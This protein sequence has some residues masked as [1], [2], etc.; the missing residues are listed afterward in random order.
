[1]ENMKITNPLSMHSVSVSNAFFVQCQQN[2]M[3]SD[4]D[5]LVNNHF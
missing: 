1:M 5:K 3:A 4:A 2:T